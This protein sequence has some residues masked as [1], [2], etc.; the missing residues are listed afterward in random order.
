VYSGIS[1]GA[2]PAPSPPH[3]Y[4]QMNGN[5][6]GNQLRVQ[7]N[8]PL[9]SSSVLD[10][11][12]SIGHA[13]EDES[14]E[15]GHE[16]WA[17]RGRSRERGRNTNRDAIVYDPDS[18]PDEY[19][20]VNNM[21]G[22]GLRN[23]AHS[24][25]N[26]GINGGE[27]RISGVTVGYSYSEDSPHHHSHSFVQGQGHGQDF[28][29]NAGDAGMVGVALAPSDIDSDADAEVAAVASRF[30]LEDRSRRENPKLSGHR[31]GESG[32][33]EPSEEDGRREEEDE[34]LTEGEER[35]ERPTR[36]G[37]KRRERMR[38]EAE[39]QIQQESQAIEQ[40]VHGEKE[41]KQEEEEEEQPLDE[42]TVED[43]PVSS[44]PRVEEK[45][46]PVV[47]EAWMAGL[48]YSLTRCVA[49]RTFGRSPR[50]LF[51]P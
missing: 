5:I 41:P 8:A 12:D 47:L 14:S 21:A 7:I 9:A 33:F 20:E 32:A 40:P 1:A 15:Y 6:N 31:E 3:P 51:F 49:V 42:V 44:A 45:T 19:G 11:I 27:Y 22:I 17:G 36:I 50:L 37:K 25:A 16:P 13:L 28:V 35:A 10:H 46:L 18:S 43:A 30:V 39:V 23:S 34:D 4:G 24:H 2:G 48:I 38:A 26:G 29:V